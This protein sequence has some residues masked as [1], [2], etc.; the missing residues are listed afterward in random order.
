MS[1][2]AEP[3]SVRV[4]AVMAVAVLGLVAV[5]TLATWGPAAPWLPKCLL[6]ESTGLLCPG[7]GATRASHAL[8]HGRLGAAVR[9]NPLLVSLLALVP[10]ALIFRRRMGIRTAWALVALVVVFGILRNLPGWPSDL[11][12]PP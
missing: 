10:F 8:L 5:V 4:A 11:L 3:R 12:A 1:P 9:Y 2:S 7:C 6:H